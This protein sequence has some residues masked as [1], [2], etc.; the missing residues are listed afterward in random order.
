VTEP[1]IRGTGRV[2]FVGI[3]LFIVGFFNLVYGVALLAN[4]EIVVTGPDSNVVLL[5]DVTTWGWVLLILG[6]IQILAAA[7]VAAGQTWA[8]VFGI[9]GA[10]LAALA[11]LPVIAGP[12]PI[13]SLLIILGCV[14]IIHGLVVYGEPA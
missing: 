9:V 14:W 2:I 13:W 7:G 10:M 5:G 8:R 12:N 6:G 4:D 3:I 1:A 11:Q